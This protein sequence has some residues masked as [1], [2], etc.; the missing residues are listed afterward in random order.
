MDQLY[1]TVRAAIACPH[2]QQPPT[3]DVFRAAMKTPERPLGCSRCGRVHALCL[4]TTPAGL[5]EQAP[6]GTTPYDLNAM[7]RS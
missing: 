7:N 6:R 2:C 5:D 1:M 4:W 3:R